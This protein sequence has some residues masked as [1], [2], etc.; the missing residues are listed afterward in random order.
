MTKCWGRLQFFLILHNEIYRYCLLTFSLIF[1]HGYY[2]L[3]SNMLANYVLQGLKHFSQFLFEHL[4]EKF[5]I[6]MWLCF[7]YDEQIFIRVYINKNSNIINSLL[8]IFR[9]HKKEKRAL[10]LTIRNLSKYLIGRYK[11]NVLCVRIFF[12]S[13]GNLSRDFCW[14]ARVYFKLN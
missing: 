7:C 14:I 1:F 6:E 11:E 13:F 10:R 9:F 12:F 4:G 8:T 3:F 2:V 5:F